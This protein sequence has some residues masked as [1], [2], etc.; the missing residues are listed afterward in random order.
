MQRLLIAALMLSV[1]SLSVTCRRSA[2]AT[3]YASGRVV[4]SAYKKGAQE[5]RI[6]LRPNN[7]IIVPANVLWVRELNGLVYGE[8]EWV[9]RPG[10]WMDERW[11]YAGFFAIDSASL[12]MRWFDTRDALDRFLVSTGK[13]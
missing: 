11:E 9:Q 12:K 3:S 5:F 8:K 2:S 4:E 7:D 6:L 10:E 1:V 13:K